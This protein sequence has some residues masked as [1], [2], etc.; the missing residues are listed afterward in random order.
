MAVEHRK[1]RFKAYFGGGI[2]QFADGPD[3]WGEAKKSQGRVGAGG[4]SVLSNQ[5]D[6]SGF[7]AIGGWSGTPRRG[8]KCTL[9]SGQLADTG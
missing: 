9:G 2:N 8:W 6:D 4:G 5:K 1:N 7:P 3:E